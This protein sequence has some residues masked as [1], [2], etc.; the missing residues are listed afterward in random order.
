MSDYNAYGELYDQRPELIIHD[1]LKHSGTIRE[2]IQMAQQNNYK[3]SFKRG[4]FRHD[5]IIREGGDSPGKP[6]SH[7]I[8]SGLRYFKKFEN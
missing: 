7:T 3:I 6:Q 2:V 4:P 1:R 5:L 8:I